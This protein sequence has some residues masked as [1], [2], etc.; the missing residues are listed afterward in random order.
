MA[1]SSLFGRNWEH[2]D[3]V[4]IIPKQVEEAAFSKALEKA[5]GEQKVAEAIKS[6]MSAAKAWETFG[7]M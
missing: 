6:G 7:I 1:K 3:G 4:L 5:R 2:V